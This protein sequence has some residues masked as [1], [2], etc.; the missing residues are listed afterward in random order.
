[1]Q[2]MRIYSKV[3]GI[4]ACIAIAATGVTGAE[5]KEIEM[6]LDRDGRVPEPIVAIETA[7]WPNLTRLP[8]GD[9]VALIYNQPSHGLLPGDVE[10]WAST[11]EGETWTKRSVAAPRGTPEQNRMNVAAGLTADGDLILVTSGWSDPGNPEAQPGSNYGHGLPAWVCISKDHGHTWTID[12][13][14]FPTTPDGRP[15]IP[16]GDIMPGADGLLRVS[17]YRGPRGPRDGE[18]PPVPADN[19]LATLAAKG[20][21][22]IVRGNG[23]TWNPPTPLTPETGWNNSFNETA[24][25]H[26]GEGKWLAA[27]RFGSGPTFPH[28]STDDAQTWTWGSRIKGHPAHLLELNDGTIVLSY[29]KRGKERRGIDVVFSDE[30]GKKKTW[31]EP[32]RIAAVE[33][34]DMGYPSSVLRQDGQIVTAYY[35]GGAGVDGYCMKIV[36]WD[37]AKTRAER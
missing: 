17:A 23:K 30:R 21:N 33:G 11:D 12:R 31:S 32:Y 13:D 15:L 36:V 35:E 29:G 6:V 3:L 19:E 5:M 27:A 4:A 2:E 7:A 34:S 18:V 9:I 37:P 1:M 14:S 24:I 22:W 28:V 26:L 16:F 20:Q 25:L 8:N 10:C